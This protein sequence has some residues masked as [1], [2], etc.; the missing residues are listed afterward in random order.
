MLAWTKPTEGPTTG[1]G[2]KRKVLILWVFYLKVN[3]N[4]KRWLNQLA[5]NANNL[6]NLQR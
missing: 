6:S 5:G 3:R 2:L 1:Q 4:R